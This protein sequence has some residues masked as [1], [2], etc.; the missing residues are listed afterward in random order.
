MHDEASSALDPIRALGAQL[1][2]TELAPFRGARRYQVDGWI[3]DWRRRGR[4]EGS[5]VG[6]AFEL[7]GTAVRAFHVLVH[8]R[9]RPFEA[10]TTVQ[11]VVRRLQVAVKIAQGRIVLVEPEPTQS[12]S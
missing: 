1:R 6:F 2:V 11:D 5:S 3:S 8:G 10:V 7:E 12:L 9:V 4:R